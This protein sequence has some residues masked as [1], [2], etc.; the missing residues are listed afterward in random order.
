MR[1]CT[2]QCPGEEEWVM[3]WSPIF[4]A[5]FPVIQLVLMKQNYFNIVHDFFLP[6]VMILYQSS[7][8]K[9]AMFLYFSKKQSCQNSMAVFTEKCQIYKLLLEFQNSHIYLYTP[10]NPAANWPSTAVCIEIVLHR[11]QE[12]QVWGLYMEQRS[13]QRFGNNFKHCYSY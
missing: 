2:V 4:H 11:N 3:S 7:R 1:T 10:Y 8:F 9:R 13:I 6:T 5:I 12:L